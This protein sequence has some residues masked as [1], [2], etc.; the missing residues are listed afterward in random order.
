MVDRKGD[1]GAYRQSAQQGTKDAP[2][3]N[4]GLRDVPR[5]ANCSNGFAHIQEPIH[6]RDPCAFLISDA[7]IGQICDPTYFPVMLKLFLATLVLVLALTVGSLPTFAKSNGGK[8]VDNVAATRAYL[9]ARVP[10]RRRLPARSL[11]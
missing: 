10:T 5:L 4:A 6:Q 11:R 3:S 7:Q 9:L 8:T 1:D 2:P